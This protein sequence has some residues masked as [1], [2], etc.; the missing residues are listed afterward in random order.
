MV[1]PRFFTFQLLSIFRY[2]VSHVMIRATQRR[3]TQWLKRVRNI[4]E[5][6]VNSL[7][8]SRRTRHIPMKI[9]KKTRNVTSV[10]ITQHEHGLVTR[11]I[12]CPVVTFNDTLS[13]LCINIGARNVH[14]DNRDLTEFP[15]QIVRSKRDSQY[16]LRSRA[17][18]FMNT[19]VGGPP[20]AD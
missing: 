19:E 20:F 2:Q 10:K 16:F 13:C 4:A 7:V 11:P 5:T 6:E 17:D 15:W 12:Y 9:W 8:E 14:G 18:T 3:P 1:C